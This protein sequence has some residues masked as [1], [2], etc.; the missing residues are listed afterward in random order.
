MKVKEDKFNQILH[1]GTNEF[2]SK[3]CEAASMHNI[4]ATAL[5]SKRTLY[6]Y[7]S[8]KELLFDAIVSQLLDSML[9]YCELEYVPGKR[10]EDQLAE[11]ID[12]R[13][14]F[15][16]G[17]DYLAMSRLILSELLRGRKLSQAHLEKIGL[18]D[19]HFVKWIDDAKKD[20]KILDKY[21]NW[22]ISKQFHSIIKGDVFYPVVEGFKNPADVDVVSLKT[23]L[24]DF[25]MLF[26]A[27]TPKDSEG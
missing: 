15:L 4:A 7:F 22:F 19:G 24:I 26:F 9:S 2:L 17:E 16:T 3:G 14:A 27:S 21:D 11:V 23:F 8:S 25:F 1:A 10:F 6:K 18:I 12:S 13:I 5:V 20:G